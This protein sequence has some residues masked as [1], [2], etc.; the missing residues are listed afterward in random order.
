MRARLTIAL[1]ASLALAG[2]GPVAVQ[3]GG[4]AL[5]YATSNPQILAGLVNGAISALGVRPSAV[6]AVNAKID[7][8]AQKDLTLVCSNLKVAKG[9]Y[10]DAKAGNTLR[11]AAE[12]GEAAAAAVLDAYCGG[13]RPTDIGRAVALAAKA[14]AATQKATQIPGT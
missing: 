5:S 1:A 4:A 2:C 13:T 3:V 9:Y 12:K 11:P 7:G 14:L 6:A 10:D 8:F